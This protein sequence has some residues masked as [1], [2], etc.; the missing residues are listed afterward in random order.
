M[1]VALFV[2]R[3]G[4]G[5][6]TGVD[7]YARELIAALAARADHEVVAFSTAER[8]GAGWVP[9]GV[10]VRRVPGPRR[11]VHLTWT[12]LRRPLV[13]RVLHDIDVVHV[14]APTFPVPATAPLVYTVHDLMPSLHPEW[15]D[16]RHR[17]GFR[18]AIAHA[19]EHATAVIADSAATAD[20]AVTL[21]GIDRS[22]IV[23]VPL[24]VAPRFLHPVADAD[25]AR[26]T[27][28]LG[29]VE[30]S[31]VTYVGHFDER[32]NVAILVEALARLGGHAP[33]L[34]VAGPDSPGLQ[35]VRRLVE[36]SGLTSRVRFAGFVP[37]TDLPALLAGAKA[38]L[39]PSRHE[40]FGLPPLEAMAVGTPAIVADTAALSDTVGD[41]ALVAG[42]DDADAWAAA[43]SSLD[44]SELAEARSALGREHAHRFTWE[45]T[46]SEVVAVYERAAAEG[47]RRG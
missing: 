23:V 20:M 39:H 32:K 9:P 18:H 42:A 16:R 26:V 45:R 2:H 3:L 21:A 35:R 36:A 34:V 29:V 28:R 25:V 41:A 44:D 22:R 38:L 6:P 47:S 19:R 8:D 10:E 30:K 24:G 43:I 40:G 11:V 46:A 17:W 31:Y 37:D 12:L 1:K 15:F 13:D 5:A 14:T 4:T 7:R 33:T 27:K